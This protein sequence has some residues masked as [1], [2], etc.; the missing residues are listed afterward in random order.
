MGLSTADFT[1]GAR[2]PSTARWA[3]AWPVGV[4][5]FALVRLLLTASE[6]GSC[7]GAANPGSLQ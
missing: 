3:V 1:P 5:K 7:S 6:F 2:Q 4:G